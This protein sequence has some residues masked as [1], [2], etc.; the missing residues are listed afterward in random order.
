VAYRRTAG[1]FAAAWM[2]NADDGD[3]YRLAFDRPG[4]WSQ[5]YNLIWDRILDLRLFPEEVVRKELAF[6]RKTQNR[7]GI[8]LDN[9][10]EFTKL[11]WILW[12]ASLTGS[13][14]DFAALVAPVYDFLENTPDRVPMTDW[15]WTKDAKMRGFRARPV[16][17]GVFIKLLDDPRSGRSGRAAAPGSAASGPRFP[18]LPR[19]ACWWRPP[20]RSRSAGATPS[21]ARRR[22]GRSPGSTTPAGRRAR[23]FR[24]PADA[25]HRGQDRMEFPGDLAPAR[26]H[27]PGGP[28]RRGPVLIY[29]DEDVEVHL[30]GVPAAEEGGFTTNYGLVP[31]SPA[32][33][34]ALEAG[35]EP[36][37]PP[38]PP[39]AG[40]QYSRRRAGDGGAVSFSAARR[41]FTTETRRHGEPSLSE[42]N[43][44]PK[45]V[46]PSQ[47]TGIKKA[48]R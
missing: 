48:G 44:V 19:S 4:T 35:E 23:R 1:E 29:H 40:G 3:H 12:S 41:G 46:I 32:G 30:N 15:Y 13:R 14:E 36:A 9:R 2:R 43:S 26:D 37:R 20:G 47:R 7:Y 10:R 6:Y 34:A 5:K 42:S 45:D 39:D 18:S 38:L 17:G 33:R 31:L 21:P 27:R 11:D 24:H 28:N 25:Q 16:V 22:A 8:P